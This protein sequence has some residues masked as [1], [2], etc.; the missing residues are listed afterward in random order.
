MKKRSKKI[1]TLEIVSYSI[2]GVIALWGVT[3][4]VLGLVAEFAPVYSKDNALLEASNA[5]AK[6]FGQGFLFYGCINFAAGVVGVV[7]TLL[8]YSK[9]ADR[10]FEKE[11]RRAAIRASAQAS[12][13]S[14]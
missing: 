14:K 1:S 11:Q 9:K 13:E 12:I 3:F 10:D 4:I 2:F 5:Y 6:V 8:S 7:S